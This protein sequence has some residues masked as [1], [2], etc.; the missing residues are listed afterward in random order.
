VL[1]C[2]VVAQSAVVNWER[3][4]RMRQRKVVTAFQELEQ[5]LKAAGQPVPRGMNYAYTC[6]TLCYA[7]LWRCGAALRPCDVLRRLCVAVG[8][9]LCW[10]GAGG[11]LDVIPLLNSD[12]HWH[13]DSL[14]S[15]DALTKRVF[16]LCGQPPPPIPAPTDPSTP[17]PFA[18]FG[19]ASAVAAVSGGG[20][21]PKGVMVGGDASALASALGGL[22]KTP[23]RAPTLQ[24]PTTAAAPASASPAPSPS[25][26]A[27]GAPQVPAA[28]SPAAKP[29]VRSQHH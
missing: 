29:A 6:V 5:A 28:N 23:A 4:F 7:L 11:A 12:E 15:G 18:P 19:G 8:M 2:V 16:A 1:C 9:G 17:T 20:V 3:E 27:G 21:A 14:R 24:T 26:S 25:A 10:C 13:S 22:R